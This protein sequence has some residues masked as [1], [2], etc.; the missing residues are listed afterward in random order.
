MICRKQAYHLSNI[1][2]P[3]HI[4]EHTKLSVELA[5]FSILNVFSNSLCNNFYPVLTF[6]QREHRLFQMSQ[7][8]QEMSTDGSLS[9]RIGLF[10]CLRH[11][12]GLSVLGLQLI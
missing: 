8:R 2:F 11:M 10:C 3:V 9:K 5:M 12:E 1:M 4:V 7:K 6:F